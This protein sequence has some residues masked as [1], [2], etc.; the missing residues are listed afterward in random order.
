MGRGL[1]VTQRAILRV[2]DDDPEVCLAVADIAEKVG[3]SPARS[4]SPS[5]PSKLEA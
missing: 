4:A 5:T 3:A 2:L 1:G